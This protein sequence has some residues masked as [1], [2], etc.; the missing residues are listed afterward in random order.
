MALTSMVD[1][2]A[3]QPIDLLLHDVLGQPELRDAVDEHPARGVEG[4]EDG[5]LVAGLGELSGGRQAGR[6]GADDGDAPTGIGVLAH[7]QLIEVLHG[8]VSHETLQGADRHGLALLAPDAQPFALGLLGTDAPG[9]TRQR[10]VVEQGFGGALEVTPGQQLDEARDV[11]AHRTTVDA[12]GVPAV[13]ATLGFLHG[14][15]LGVA[16]VDLRG[17]PWSRMTADRA[18]T[19]WR[20]ICIRSWGE[21]SG[22]SVIVACHLQPRPPTLRADSDCP[23]RP[24]ARGRGTSPAGRTAA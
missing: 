14:Q 15:H 4:L 10:V 17:S 7:V 18:G 12:A 24:S 6:P 22:R 21:S 19:S 8:P 16:Q 13:Q 3:A 23:R 5:H 2:Q 9:H 11:D 20:S 1:A